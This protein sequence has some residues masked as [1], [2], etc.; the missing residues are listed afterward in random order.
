MTTR[1]PSS[2]V[3]IDLNAALRMGYDVTGY[4]LSMGGKYQGTIEEVDTGF[5]S[6]TYSDAPCALMRGAWGMCTVVMPEKK[7]RGGQ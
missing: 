4:G 1:L 7:E 6:I 5:G 3:P 2:E